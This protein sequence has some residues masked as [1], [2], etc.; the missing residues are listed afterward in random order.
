MLPERALKYFTPCQG[1]IKWTRGPGQSRDREAPETL[2]AT[3]QRFKCP[4]C[5]FAEAPVK[6]V[7]TDTI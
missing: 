6:N 2:S 7:K 1:Q 4:R 5:N 3:A